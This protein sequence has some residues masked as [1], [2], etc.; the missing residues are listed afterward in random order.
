MFHV[1][2]YPAQDVGGTAAEAAP[3]LR[4]QHLSAPAATPTREPELQ[5]SS[6]RPH[7]DLTAPDP[8]LVFA[9]SSF[10]RD[11]IEKAKAEAARRLLARKMV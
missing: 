11:I 6:R 4:P 10:V 9:A 1:D 7:E 3:L 5:T 2:I 8:D